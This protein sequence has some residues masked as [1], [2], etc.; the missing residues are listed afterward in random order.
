MKYKF[1]PSQI[2]LLKDCPRCFW[3]QYNKDFKRPQ[4]IF[5]SLPSGMDRILKTHFDSYAKVGE[6]PPEIK[7][8]KD[9]KLFDDFKLLDVWRSNFQGIKYECDEFILKG[10]VDAILINK[11]N[12]KLIVL[13]YKTRGYPVKEDTQDHYIEQQALYNFLLRKIGYE[14]EDYSYLLFYH[15]DKVMESVFLFHKDLIKIKTQ[16]S[17]AQN[18]I[19]KALEI[20]RGPIPNAAEE[21][22]Y[23]KYRD[24][25]IDL[26]EVEHKGKKTSLLD[27]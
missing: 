25:K 9:V 19:N 20:L 8:I 5:P 6:I 7:E 22:G 24:A 23:C 3:L 18:I 13:D 17:V 1:T 26:S 10:A 11:K 2:G 4:G 27:Y 21:C 12:N 16:D 14:T 15:P